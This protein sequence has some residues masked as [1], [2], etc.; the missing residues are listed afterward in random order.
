MHPIARK[1][2]KVAQILV[3]AAE[4]G[5]E[6]LPLLESHATSIFA[7]I[8]RDAQTPGLFDFWGRCVN[9]DEN[10][11]EVIVPPPILKAIC[12]LADVP[13]R[14]GVVHA[15][16]QHTYGYLFS[17]IE[18][19]YGYKRDRWVSTE[20]ERAFGLPSW[21][22]GPHPRAGTLLANL[23]WFLGQFAFRGW[24]R[25]R[26]K[27]TELKTAVPASLVQTDFSRLLVQRIVEKVA[28]GQKVEVTIQT[29]LVAFATPSKAARDSLL[30]Y[31]IKSTSRG[32]LRLITAFPM[33]EE[34]VRTLI[35]SVTDE[36]RTIR[37]RYNSYLPGLVGKPLKGK[38]S[39]E[40]V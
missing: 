31:S 10:T 28:V 35:Q 33:R 3:D 36:P 24:E 27:L 1:L 25:L 2:D 19:P 11:G 14:G 17:L 37:L 29:D 30:I 9:V 26:S 22:L 32:P 7:Q 18:T 16:L 34:A 39:V 12:A 23:T 38:R 40:T 21:L 13:Y 15:G 6:V 4:Q 20:L 5:R 8:E